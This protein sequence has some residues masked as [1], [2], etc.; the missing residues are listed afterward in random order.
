GLEKLEALTSDARI[1]DPLR[2]AI[3][4]AGQP[5]A[6]PEPE[7]PEINA[8]E[9]ASDEASPDEPVVYELDMAAQNNPAIAASPDLLAG[10]HEGTRHG[11]H[12]GEIHA[13]AAELELGPTYSEPPHAE[14]APTHIEPAHA[15]AV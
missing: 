15:E 5:Q 2:A 1:L 13:K 4:S 7:I 6:E 9:V 12:Q 8:D 14:P 10:Y 11:A 3:E